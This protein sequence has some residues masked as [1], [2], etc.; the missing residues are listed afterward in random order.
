MF[1]YKFT[2]MYFILFKAFKDNGMVRLQKHK[3][4]KVE[5]DLQIIKQ[6]LLYYLKLNN[7]FYY[8]YLNCRFFNVY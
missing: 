3:G 4:A 5:V 2:F 7:V 6:V 1:C 8:S